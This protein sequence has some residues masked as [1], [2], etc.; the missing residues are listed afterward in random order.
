ME[1]D[2]FQFNGKVFLPV[3]DH[4]SKDLPVLPKIPT[5]ITEDLHQFNG[6]NPAADTMGHQD[7]SK[8]LVLPAKADMEV[9]Q[10]N[11][12]PH[13]LRL[14]FQLHQQLTLLA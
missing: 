5:E 9:H 6:L 2:R 12:R 14:S 8:D 7:Q 11:A 10:H 3:A 4:I 13:Q 1:V